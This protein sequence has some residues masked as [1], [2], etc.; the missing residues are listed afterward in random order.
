MSTDELRRKLKD[1]YKAFDRAYEEGGD[2]PEFPDACIGMTCGARTR[3]GTPCKLKSIFSN[4]RCKFHGGMS[5]GPRTARGK[6][7]SA[8]NGFKPK[9]KRSHKTPF[10]SIK[11]TQ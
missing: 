9:K 7:I 11:K 10:Y 1:F 4:G 8:L 6:A 2:Y 5:A 3:A